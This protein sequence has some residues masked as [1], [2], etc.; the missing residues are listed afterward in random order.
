[1]GDNQRRRYPNRQL[2][3]HQWQLEERQREQRAISNPQH[4]AED[5][6]NKP[7]GV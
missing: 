4:E 1:V 3:Q 7:L 2:L 5:P 6:N